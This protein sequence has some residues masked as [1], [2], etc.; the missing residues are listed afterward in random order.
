[1]GLRFPLRGAP[2]VV[3]RDEECDLRIQDESVSRRHASLQPDGDDYYIIDLQSTNGTFVNGVRVTAQKLK[4]GDYLHIGNCIY[5]FLA[6]GNIE[7]AYHEEIH[8]L[9]II[10][11]LTD[12]FNR[13]YFM[14]FLAQELASASRYRRC[15][16]LAMFDADRFKSIN[17]N[18]GHLGG[19]FTL[20]EL[21]N[22]AKKSVRATDVIARYGGEEF[23][24]VMTD[25]NRNQALA[26]AERLRE[27]IAGHSFCYNGKAYPVTI[28]VGVTTF[29]GEGF[30][31]TRELIAAADAHLLKAKETGRNR[32]VG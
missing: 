21:A 1:M 3:G 20:R 4:D 30:M 11:A 8:R 18:L 28:S 26:G 7:A 29:S 13:R 17:D 22:L 31:T 2:L 24:M 27:G 25:T 6:G 15:L 19:D 9:T 23:A 12:V 5:R 16:S 10:D 14:E 32:V